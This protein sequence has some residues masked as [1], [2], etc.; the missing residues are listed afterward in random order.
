MMTRIPRTDHAVV[1]QLR[2]ALGD[3]VRSALAHSRARVAKWLADKSPLIQWGEMSS[4]LGRLYAAATGQG[5]CA[6]DFGRGETEFLKRFD[7]R[8]RLEKNP[9]SV[10]RVLVQLSEYFAG[11]R[12]RFDLPVDLS[13][14]TPFQKT[15]LEVTCRIAPGEVWTYHRVAE[16]MRRPRSS[17]PVGQALARNPVPIVIPCHRV[18]A[19]NGA[20]RGYSGGSGLKAKRWLLQL[21]GALE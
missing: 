9:K 7:P 6:V 14:L 10:E 4:P 5:L 17:R 8:A 2:S 3:P 18:I 21:E 19:S 15:V 11:K 13:T 12:T 1:K 16:A 20:L